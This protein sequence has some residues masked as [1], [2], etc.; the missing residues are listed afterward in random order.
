MLGMSFPFH[1]IAKAN[2]AELE[3]VTLV[4]FLIGAVTLIFSAV[5]LVFFFLF[6]LLEMPDMVRG[7]SCGARV[8]W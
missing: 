3:S 5:A 2:Y 4:F 6:F 8:S 7:P 1:H